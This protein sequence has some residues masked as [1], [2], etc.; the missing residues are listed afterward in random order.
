MKKWYLYNSTEESILKL[1]QLV[2]EIPI[3]VLDEVKLQ[4]FVAEIG[5]PFPSPFALIPWEHHIQIMRHSKT[6]DEALFYLGRT[7]SG[8]WG[9]QTLDNC[10]HANLYKTQGHALTNFQAILP[11][12]Q[13]RLAQEIVKE[14]DVYLQRLLE[15]YPQ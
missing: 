5:C 12:V 7:I 1:R 4:H 2:A 11:E 14:K 6:I 15:I 10:L 3:P 13:G 9:R 8:G